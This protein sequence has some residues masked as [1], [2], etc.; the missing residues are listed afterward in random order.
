MKT[1]KRF[2]LTISTIVLLTSTLIQ[3]PTVAAASK[4]PLAKNIIVMISDGWSWNHITA[5][6]YYRTGAAPNQAYV[7][8]PFKHFMSTYEYD[9]SYDPAVAWAD[10]DYVKSGATDSA[11][12]ATT[13]S[14][15]VKTYGGAIGVDQWRNPI[16]H[17]LELAE[18][19]GKATVGALNVL[20]S[21]QD[22]LFLMVEGGAIDWASHGNQ[23]GRMIEEQV[24]FDNA[25]Q[26][27]VDWVKANSNWGETLLIV[28]GDH[29][30][31]Y[32]TGPSSDPTWEPIVN[33]GAGVLPGME[34]HSGSHT[35]SLIP[36]YAKGD[37]ARLFNRA[38][39]QIRPGSITRQAAGIVLQPVRS[40]HPS[41]CAVRYTL[42][43][44]TGPGSLYRVDPSRYHRI[45]FVEAF[46]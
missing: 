24:D 33:S 21:D 26:A 46:L 40:P 23:S 3:A 2:M 17:A 39:S 42:R 20:D 10:F 15:G 30:T 7:H 12:A 13:M 38:V 8:F 29:E 1:L 36:V 16:Q 5:T 45:G 19:Q 11:A 4:K 14:T 31:G 34:W 41:N 35:N 6:S 44:Q 18:E 22:G 43:C 25:V 28:T 32:L 27:V 37:A 9:G